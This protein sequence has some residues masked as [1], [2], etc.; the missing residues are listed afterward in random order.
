MARK[1]KRAK[2]AHKRTAKRK[3]VAP[4]KR[5]SRKRTPVVKKSKSISRVSGEQAL[6][7]AARSPK[8]RRIVV[9]FR[10]T[11]KVPHTSG[12]KGK[13]GNWAR[14]QELGVKDIVPIFDDVQLARR[15]EA[16]SKDVKREDWE[17]YS[18][19][20]FL[21]LK[22]SANTREL[23][24]VL[25]TFNKELRWAYEDREPVLACPAPT[26]AD[27]LIRSDHLNP[28]PK[29]VDSAAAWQIDGGQ[30]EQQFCVDVERGWKKHERI[31]HPLRVKHLCGRMQF[32]GLAHGTQ[33]LGI[34]C[35][36]RSMG[37][38][39]GIVPELAEIQLA[40]HVPA[41]FVDANVPLVPPDDPGTPE[42]DNLYAAVGHA[43]D[44]LGAKAVPL[45]GSTRGV[46]LIE[47]QTPND[48][49]PM[50]ILPLMRELIRTAGDYKVAVVEAA[51]NWEPPPATE[52]VPQPPPP[53][54]RDLDLEK[55]L[56]DGTTFPLLRPRGAVDSGA[57]MVGSADAAVRNGKHDRFATSNF[58][59]R[60]D[61]YAWGEGIRAPTYVPTASTTAPVDQCEDFGE[62]SGAAAII[63]GV[64]LQ[65]LGVAARHGVALDPPTLRSL[66]CD[67]LLGTAATDARIKTMPDLAKIL[68][69]FA[70]RFGVSLMPAPVS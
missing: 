43:I 31:A 47:Y 62:T 46:M 25:R 44:L 41:S 28:A 16:R 52:E 69:E 34:L 58:G 40:S 29:G 14:V 60:V 63:A 22:P 42:P 2:N 57:I 32:G 19:A 24:E 23:L 30:G 33:V 55:D 56:I 3:K 70:T 17:S 39:Q 13:P 65:L 53:W 21:L 45:A 50:E 7:D 27:C 20:F 64:A 66:L 18:N 4:R 68:A 38:C 61:C 5:V 49:L 67:P 15:L 26:K 11:I 6:I 54:G 8:G 37:G 9:L 36:T 51:G 10:K 59:S 1:T 12:F 35:G 48:G